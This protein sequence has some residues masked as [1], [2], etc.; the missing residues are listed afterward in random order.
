MRNLLAIAAGSLALVSG[1]ASAQTPFVGEVQWF[2]NNF[3]PL[4][5]APADGALVPISQNEVL[6][7]LLGTTYGG[8]GQTTFALPDLRSRIAIHAGTGPGLSNNFLG[9]QGGSEQATVTVNQMP[10]HNHVLSASAT[11][12]AS[13]SAATTAA[14]AGAALANGGTTRA[15][16]SGPATVDMGPSLSA[17]GALA[18]RKSVV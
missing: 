3:C 5:W 17:T 7:T 16:A 8:D 12:R 1:A 18:D 11:L 10:T 13:A 9:Q 15:Y 6:F 2:A 14:P 4:G